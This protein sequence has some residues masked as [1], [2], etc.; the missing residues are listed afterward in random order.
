MEAR[1]AWWTKMN[2]NCMKVSHV[3]S[4]QTDSRPTGR[5]RQ[6]RRSVATLG[7]AVSEAGQMGAVD[8]DG[9]RDVAAERN[10]FFT[11]SAAT[12]PNM[13]PLSPVRGPRMAGGWAA[14][15]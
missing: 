8:L 11:S 15:R 5:L 3:S 4:K 9:A 7:P 2:G 6:F 13:R 10:R 14:V 1:L 12:A